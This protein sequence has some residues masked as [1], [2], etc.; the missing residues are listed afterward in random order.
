MLDDDESGAEPDTEGSDVE[1]VEGSAALHPHFPSHHHAPSSSQQPASSQLFS[2]VKAESQS[3]LS[4]HLSQPPKIKA[5]SPTLT[6]A[7]DDDDDVLVYDMGDVQKNLEKERLAEKQRKIE[8]EIAA[9]KQRREEEASERQALQKEREEEEDEEDEDGGG[10]LAWEV[11][12]SA[13]TKVRSPFP[14]LLLSSLTS[15]CCSPTKPTLN[16]S[17]KAVPSSSFK[18][19]SR[20]TLVPTSFLATQPTRRRSRRRST[21]F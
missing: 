17:R 4:Q 11:G 6:D 3:Q 16:P 13:L 12:S 20:P 8:A 7:E 5:E 10:R 21:S 1:M 15:S 19:P 9:A 2:S 18:T 14:P